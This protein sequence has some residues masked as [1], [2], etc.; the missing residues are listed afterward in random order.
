MRTSLFGK[1]LQPKWWRARSM[2]VCLGFISALKNAPMASRDTT[3]KILRVIG[4]IL[5]KRSMSLFDLDCHGNEFTL[6]CEDPQPPHL[7]LVELRYS[8]AE[9]NAFDL[10]AKA[11]RQEEFKLVNFRSLSEVLRAL[12]RRIDDRS[13]RLLR[14]SNSD[15]TVPLDA[16][17]IEYQT[18]DG[19]RR[20]E[21]IS[22]EAVGDHA[23]HMYKER[24]RRSDL[25]AP[26]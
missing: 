24:L 7:N 14:I 10:N 13:G 11:N 8:V 25:D 26:R 17:K 22:A 4:Q 21:E 9:I 5:E 18:R 6:L 3:S 1:Y 2:R 12:G 15:T 16:I 19:Q 20:S 23:I